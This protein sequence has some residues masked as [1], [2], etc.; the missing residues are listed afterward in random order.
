VALEPPIAQGQ[1]V[2]LVPDFT[3]NL[4]QK[5]GRWGQ[6]RGLTYLSNWLPVFAFYADEVKHFQTLSGRGKWQPTPFIPWH[7]PFFNG[8]RGIYTARVPLPECEHVAVSG[9]S[10]ELY[11]D[12]RR[13]KNSRR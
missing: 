2:T 12:L 5:M 10:G 11:A 7:Q 9:Q 1:S 3:F 6:W 4:P 13:P 8:R